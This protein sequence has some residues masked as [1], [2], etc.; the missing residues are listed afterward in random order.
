ML[1]TALVLEGVDHKTAAETCGMDRQTPRDWVHR[2]NADG[3]SGLSNRR[4]PGRP[5]WLTPAQ[6]AALVA[7]VEQDPDPE[8]YGVMRWR[9]KD[10]KRRIEEMLGAVMQ[11][12]TVAAQLAE[13][14]FVRLTPRPRHPKPGEGTQG[15]AKRL[16][17]R[18]GRNRRW[19]RQG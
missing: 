14:A 5:P 15:D 7:L 4:S 8:R 6:K 10:L 17:R 2:Y 1:A 12:R 16:P 9:R 3:L 19:P 13:L 18:S 11:E